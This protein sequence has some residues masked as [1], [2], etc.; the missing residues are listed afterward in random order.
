MVSVR[1]RASR[2][3][4]TSRC[5]GGVHY[6]TTNQNVINCSSVDW[7]PLRDFLGLRSPHV[8]ALF[9]N[10]RRK[11]CYIDFISKGG[12]HSKRRSAYFC[13]TEFKPVLRVQRYVRIEW[14]FDPSTSKSIH[15]WERTLKEKETL[16]SQ[17][18]KYS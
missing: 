17:T 3:L 11:T 12:R 8:R 4:G 15:Q 7:K 10:R 5:G 13:V 6:G 1:L 16:V 9:G 2:I 18:G 14:N